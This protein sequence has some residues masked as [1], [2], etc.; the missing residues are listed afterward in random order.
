MIATAPAA[1]SWFH[2]DPDHG[3]LPAL[4]LVLTMVTGLVD[5]VSYM[6]L[7]HV[8][9]ANMTGNIAFLG[10]AVADAKEFS[11]S[12]TLAATGLFLVG[13]LAGGWLGARAGR[14]RGRFLAGSIFIEI[15]LIATALSALAL[16]SDPEGSTTRYQLIAL[17]A[18]TMGVQNAVAR[19]L[20]VPDLSTTVLTLTLTGLAADSR[21][22]GGSNPRPVRRLAA[23]G[24]MFLGAALGTF[25]I[26][27]ASVGLV[28]ALALALLL[29]AAIAALRSTPST[30]A[31]TVGT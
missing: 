10:F 4:L 11:V 18:L 6:K 15:A 9:V 17:L 19:R 23:T 12:A 7:G 13:A 2:Q 26:L 14:H 25:L 8:F 28:L 5:A 31:W 3:P 1:P 16:A 20:G 27:N 21:I 30:A 24:T 22:V 29:S